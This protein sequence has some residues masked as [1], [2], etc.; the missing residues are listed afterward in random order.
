MPPEPVD[1]SLAARVERRLALPVMMA[2]VMS[3]PAVFMVV[4][5]EGAVADVGL[6]TNWTAGAVLWC[7]WLVLLV[8]AEDRLDWMRRHKWTIAVA[9]LTIP[10]AIFTLGPVQLLRLVYVVAGLRILSVRRIIS[11]G[12]V[13]ARRLNLVG[14][15]R[16][17]LLC[18]TSAIVALFLSVLL[19][20]PNAQVWLA[21]DL[22]FTQLGP[23]PALVISAILLLAAYLAWRNRKGDQEGDREGEG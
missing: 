14:W 4:W 7:E 23:V 12:K 8:L 13:L 16:I 15:Q 2:A 9:A 10:A 3:V 1:Q 19:L 17:V 6:V 21:G 20:A 18:V 11:A 22:I 5:G